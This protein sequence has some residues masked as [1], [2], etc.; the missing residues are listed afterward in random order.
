MTTAAIV[1]EPARPRRPSSAAIGARALAEAAL[2]AGLDEVVV[3]L[4]APGEAEGVPEAATVLVD[5]A[6]PASEASALHAALDYCQRAG[7]DAAVVALGDA[8]GSAGAARA[9]P[10][11]WRRAAQ[12]PGPV[13][14]V[15]A[16]RRFT[17]LVRLAAEVWPLVPLDGPVA[18]LW[19][20][21]PELCRDEALDRFAGEDD[22]A[23]GGEWASPSERAAVEA[24]LGRRAS[25]PFRVV[26]RDRA[27]GPVVIEN[28]PFL[29]D[30]RPMP[31]RYWL[32]GRAEREAVGRLEAAGGVAAAEAAVPAEAIAEAHARYAA[33]RDAAVPPGWSGPRPS[34]GVGG[35]ARGVKCLHAHL[36]WYLAGGRDPVGRWVALRLQPG[37][38]GPVAAVDC[39]TNST[40]LLV[41]GRDGA[42]LARRMTIT[43]LGEG[44]EET[45]VLAEA[46]IERTLAALAAYREE[47]DALG[48]VAV[49][50]IATSAARRAANAD[51]LLGRAEAI[52]GVAPELLDGREEGRLAYRG[53]TASLEPSAG[54]Y[55]VVDLGGGSTELVAGP[56]ES[57]AVCSLEVGCVRLTERFLRHD[58]PLRAELEA[59]G[60]HVR[61]LAAEA[62]AA[63]PALRA[64]ARLVGVAGTVAALAALDL[65]L[66]AYDGERLHHAVLTRRAVERWRDELA[67]V[68]VERRRARPGLEPGRAD[69]IVG[70]A[71]VL[72]EVMAALGQRE[73]VV[74]ERDILDGVAA[75]LLERQAR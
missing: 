72:A 33:E 14:V 58:P 57:P 75:E 52:L 61:A 11:A 68:R 49:R 3:V 74:S 66:P 37:L 40:R 32:V 31:T 2:R 6:E 34:G 30:G 10:A 41:L 44:V 65:G 25:A 64:P 39:G 60:A 7:H 48:V 21:H 53:A 1:L 55:V 4:A 43:R 5:W 29:E 16:G 19:R 69:V 8:D 54:P 59:A 17:G 47:L 15:R 13:A 35:S 56:A 18:R 9:R 24:L 22:D 28:A 27:G 36:A 71:I 63:T 26:V 12:A 51:E 45:G 70:G 42:P 38:P 73:L 23:P 67:A 50:A 62:L 20:Q 46:A